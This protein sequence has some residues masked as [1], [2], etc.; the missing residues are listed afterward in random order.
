[1]LADRVGPPGGL[2]G[3]IGHEAPPTGRGRGVARLAI[4]G[5]LALVRVEIGQRPQQQGL[6]RSRGPAHGDARAGG[7]VEAFEGN[8]RTPEGTDREHRNDDRRRSSRRRVTQGV[9]PSDSQ[10]SRAGS[11]SPIP[12]SL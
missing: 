9:A 11:I 3:E 6:A 1:M 7:Q 12:V 4:E 2:G 5:H 10:K 8:P